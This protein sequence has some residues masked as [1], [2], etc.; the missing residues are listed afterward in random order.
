MMRMLSATLSATARALRHRPGRGVLLL[1]VC[2]ALSGLHALAQDSTGQDD[3]D[4]K[5]KRATLTLKAAPKFSF[6]PARVVLSAELKGGSNDTDEYY[7]PSIEW[8]WGDDTR[9]ESTR[10]C[11][12]FQ[13]GKSSIQRRW[14]ASHTFNTAGAYRIILR[15]RRGTKTIVAGNAQ[16]QVKA[17]L[18]DSSEF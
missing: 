13:A 12:P 11:E 10:D 1:A 16:V 14:T 4:K 15:L 7:C 18:R 6:S 8:E 9:S 17:G 3:K 5:E 2:L